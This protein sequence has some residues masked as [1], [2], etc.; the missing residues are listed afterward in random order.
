M[1]GDTTVIGSATRSNPQ[2]SSFANG[3][4]GHVLDFDDVS[5]PM[6]GHP[7][8][9][10]LP[11]ALA[12]G[13]MQGVDG[14]GL[15]EA[16]IIGVEIAVKLS[17]G[18]NPAHYE[19]G[20]HS[21][22][23]LG[24]L[25]A[26]AASAKLLGLKGEQLRS[27]LAVAASQA[28]GL[29]QNFGTMTKPFHAGKAAENGVLAAILAKKG[30]TGDQKILEAPLG[31]FHLFCG[32]ENYDAD[33]VVD[34]LGKSFEMEQP[35]I[36][37][38]K[39]PSCAFS[40]PVIDSALAI[41]QDPNYRP[42]EVEV[43]EGQIH[44]LADQILIHRHPQTGLEAK[45]SAEACMAL[46][47]VDR[48]VDINSFSDDKIRSKEFQ[49]VMARVKRQVVSGSQEG[50]EEFGPA[51]VRVVMKDGKVLEATVVK[52]KGNPENPMSRQEIQEKYKGCC[53]GVLPEPSIEKSISILEKLEK[54]DSIEELMACYRVAR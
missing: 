13:E 35:G 11:A 45:F 19:H 15:L 34:Q 41:T 12:V 47:L 31:F 53:T 21:T 37:L 16:Y 44:E 26:A 17:Y 43:I 28:S 42:G 7:T 4:S 29:Q 50:P 14:Q 8:V 20:W 39:Y 9:A 36:I 23:T 30:W 49:K 24:S 40:H 6:Y 18:M 22:C 38:K 32:P 33:R 3:I 1:K 27:A 10:V 2:W 48:K 54:I 51:R 46:A 5:Q 52:A 25:G